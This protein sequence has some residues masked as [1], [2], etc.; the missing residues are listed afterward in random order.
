MQPGYCVF[1]RSKFLERIF[2]D[3]FL[4]LSWIVLERHQLKIWKL[5]NDSSRCNFFTSEKCGSFVIHCIH[6]GK[7]NKKHFVTVRYRL[8][9]S[10]TLGHSCTI[11]YN[12]NYRY[13]FNCRFKTIINIYTQ[14]LNM[15]R[16]MQKSKLG[17][18]T[19]KTEVYRIQLYCSVVIKYNFVMLPWKLVLICLHVP[20]TDSVC[21]SPSFPR[22]AH[23]Q[24]LFFY[25]H[26]V[27]S[28]AVH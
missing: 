22:W 14:S 27:S 5:R 3:F 24:H 4:F 10:L 6:C 13:M 16:C 23:S 17:E 18:I 9:L 7:G 19:V 2:R 20:F 26:W 8:V 28:A 12:C 21:I 15:H 1:L 25:F 11:S